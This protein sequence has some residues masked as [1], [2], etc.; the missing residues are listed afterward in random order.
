MDQ[1]TGELYGVNA[2]KGLKVVGGMAKIYVRLLT[3]FSQGTML[4]ELLDAVAS[5]DS[6]QI[7][8]KAHALKGVAANLSLDPLYELSLTI[9]QDAKNGVAIPANDP[10]LGELSERHRKTLA[11]IERIIAEPSILDAYK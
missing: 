1:N 8:A 9:E 3:S 11:S 6:A 4:D 10:R 2:A 5:E 7:T